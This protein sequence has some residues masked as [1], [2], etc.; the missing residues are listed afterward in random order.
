MPFRRIAPET[1]RM[2]AAASVITATIM[3]TLDTTIANVALPHMQGSM[4][5]SIDQISWVLTSYVIATAI[6]TPLT[7]YLERRLGR[8]QLFLGAVLFF[9]LS[10]T[11]CGLAASLE[12]IVLFRILQGATGACIIPLCQSVMTDLFS[13]AKRG[14]AMALWGVGVMIGP[15]LGPT[16]GGYLTDVYNWRWIFFINLPIGLLAAAGI[17]VFLPDTPIDRKSRFDLFGFT[18]L[19]IAL[20]SMQLMLDRGHT[21]DWFAS[22]EIVIEALVA[23]AAMW[24]LSLI[25]IS[26]PTRPY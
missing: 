8:R 7:G 24:V 9:I 25:H 19:S 26:E 1:A 15:I 14:Q 20:G 22:P 21:L 13:P 4:N 12:Q 3:Q 16:L 11:L 5:A 18:A 17:A 23:G 10:S 2:L 6:A